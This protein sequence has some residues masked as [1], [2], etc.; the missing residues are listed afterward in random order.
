LEERIAQII[1]EK[2]AL[3]GKIIE[4][5]GATGDGWIT[6]LDDDALAEL[7]KL[8]ADA[9]ADEGVEANDGGVPA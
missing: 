5:S 3:A 4:T 7:V 2:R 6:E 8:G 9:L 1:D